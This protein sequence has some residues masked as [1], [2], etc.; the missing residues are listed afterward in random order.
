MRAQKQPLW[1]KFQVVGYIVGGLAALGTVIVVSNKYITLP[2]AVAAVQGEVQ[3]LKEWAKEI[4]GYTRAM[5]QQRPPKVW[6]E[7][8]KDGE[9]YCSDGQQ[10]WWPNRRGECE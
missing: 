9:E 7:Q 6:K 8:G 10:Q 4:Q 1:V 3:D 2:D 5:N